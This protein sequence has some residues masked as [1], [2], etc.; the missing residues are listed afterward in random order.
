MFSLI[1][2]YSISKAIRNQEP[3]YV[4]KFEHRKTQ[5]ARY[6]FVNHSFAGDRI[7]LCGGNAGM[8]RPSQ[9]QGDPRGFVFQ[10]IDRNWK[11]VDCNKV[12]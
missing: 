10:F 2:Q 12:N 11:F 5:E 3:Y 6:E 1:S 9:F 7:V 8:A 4:L